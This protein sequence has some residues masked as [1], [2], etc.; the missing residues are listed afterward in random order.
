MNGECELP[1]RCMQEDVCIMEEIDGTLKFTGGASSVKMVTADLI[2]LQ[3]DLCIMEEVEGTLKFTAGAV[4]FP[5][6]WSLLEKLGSDM[7]AIHNPVPKYEKEVSKT[8]D[9]FMR[10]C[11]LSYTTLIDRLLSKTTGH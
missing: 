3:E 2:C 4:L 8:V 10:R 11:L 6:R 1:L 9:N 5:Q 7:H